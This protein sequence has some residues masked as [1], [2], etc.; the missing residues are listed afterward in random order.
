MIKEN[1][2]PVIFHGGGPNFIVG[3]FHKED[4]EAVICKLKDIAGDK[5]QPA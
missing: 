4:A 3:S 2:W 5:A 1:H